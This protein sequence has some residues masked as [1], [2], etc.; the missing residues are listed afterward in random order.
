MTI[1]ILGAMVEEITPILEVFQDSDIAYERIDYADNTYYKASY[2]SIQIVLAYS[3]IG[4]VFSAL[5]AATMI[6]H[7]GCEQI[8]FSG[9]AGGINPALK[10]GDLIIATKLCQHDLDITAFGHP[11][12]F[13]PGGSV[14]VD[15]DSTLNGLAIEV[16][17]EQGIKLHQ[18]IVATGDQFVYLSERKKF[19]QE[20]FKADALEMEGA[21]VACVCK[22]LSIPCLV[23][24][25]ISDTAEG[26][27]AADFDEFLKSS[28]KQSADFLL[29]LIDK[30]CVGSSK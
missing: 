8:L 5:S 16:A 22:A 23:L 11:L 27:A 18:G 6:E 4:K 20:S 1:G 3:K 10:I 19:I 26:E 29:Q 9:V 12:G 28:S 25:S 24:R 21:S 17:K 30:L 7:F 2:K 13:V 14:L 15:T